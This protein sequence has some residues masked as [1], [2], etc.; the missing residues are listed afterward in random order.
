MKALGTLTT[1][2]TAIEEKISAPSRPTPDAP[3]PTEQVTWST[4]PPQ[5]EGI[6]S[7]DTLPPAALGGLLDLEEQVGALLEE[8]LRVASSVCFPTTDGD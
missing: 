6:Q 7:R 4:L 1:Y 5:S 2:M 8:R 3:P